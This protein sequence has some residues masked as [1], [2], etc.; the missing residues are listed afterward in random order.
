MWIRDPFAESAA[1]CSLL[2]RQDGTVLHRDGSGEDELLLQAEKDGFCLTFLNME[3]RIDAEARG[4]DVRF[5]RPC[6]STLPEA[7]H[8]VR[9]LFPIM[10]LLRGHLAFHASCVSLAGKAILFM[11]PSGVGKTTAA[12][13]LVG[14]AAAKIMADDIAIVSRETSGYDAWPCS[15]AFAMRHRLLDNLP[16]FGRSVSC[17]LKRMLPVLSGHVETVRVPISCVV[18]LMPG[19]SELRPLPLME[20]PKR[21]LAQQFILSDMPA[22]LRRNLF[23]ACTAFMSQI[24]AF[25]L[26]M[27]GSTSLSLRQFSAKFSS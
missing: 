25:E 2:S 1:P 10:R 20:R 3:A 11:A 4:A 13:A 5:D 9:V 16:V 22:P 6:A 18:F 21:F 24:P 23:A 7:Y 17:G 8:R 12:A 19:Q 26:G 15:S 27:D 14:H